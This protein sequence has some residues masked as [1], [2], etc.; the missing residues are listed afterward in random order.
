MFEI[1][2]A[3]ARAN[4]TFLAA[5]YLQR[6]L[7]N[8]L[9]RSSR[10][11]TTPFFRSGKWCKGKASFLIIQIFLENYFN[12]HQNLALQNIICLSK[13]VQSNGFFFIP[14]NISSTFFN[15]FCA[16][17]TTLLIIKHLEKTFFSGRFA[18]HRQGTP[19]I[20]GNKIYII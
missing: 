1:T 9:V 14:P 8:L 19:K 7:S 17:F 5:Q 12:H 4:K 2:L 6:T 13:R 16:I 10:F 20:R 18:S 15:I 3:I 11:L